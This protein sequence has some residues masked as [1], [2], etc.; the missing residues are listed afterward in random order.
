ML[1]AHHPQDDH[2]FDCYLSAR[3]GDAVDPLV[4]EHLA[5]C[6]AC[7]ARYADLVSLMDGLAVEA[8]AESDAVFTTERLRAQ[9]Q[10]IL[11]RVEHIGR[12][13]RVISFPSHV[14]ADRSQPP[15]APHARSRWIAGAVA[16]GLF[17]GVGLGAGIEWQRQTRAGLSSS[18]V[19]V[20]ARATV[21]PSNVLL[22]PSSAPA[23]PETLTEPV[24][25]G[26]GDEA[27]LSDLEAAL[28]RTQTRELRAIDAL[29][30][31]VREVRDVR[32][33]R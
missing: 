25:E 2:L 29:T 1:R 30:P 3:H 23:E 7:A 22:P 13:A 24:A 20:D 26:R 8:A 28:E 31:H 16:A 9:Q 21:A 27:F 4:A 18:G 14:P 10:Q 32:Y 11:R 17:I 12:P 5:D 19:A 6:A 33:V 15:A